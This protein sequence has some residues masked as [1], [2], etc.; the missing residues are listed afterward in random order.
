MRVQA[1]PARP[2]VWVTR[3][4]DRAQPLVERIR[5][6]GLDAEAVP[7]LAIEPTPCTP[8]QQRILQS[9]SDHVAVVFVSTNA[10]RLGAEAIQRHWRQPLP[11]LSW[12]A[13]GAGT[14]ATLAAQGIIAR[15][16]ERADSEGLLAMAELTAERVAGQRVLLVRGRGGRTLLADTLTARGAHVVGLELYRRV[17]PPATLNRVCEAGACAPDVVLLSSGEAVR[18]WAQLVAGKPGRW[19]NVVAVVPNERCLDLARSGGLERVLVSSGADD[20]AQLRGALWAVAVE[21]AASG[22]QRKE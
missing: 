5:A 9:L 16:P 4:A 6:A 22:A 18:H 19:C 12:L 15:T 20:A 8:A 14:A 21:S 7:L 1:E 2:L 13:V 17:L 10:A 3:P 11:A